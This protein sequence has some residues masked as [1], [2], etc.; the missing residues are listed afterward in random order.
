MGRATIEYRLG[1]KQRA[2]CEEGLPVL[3]AIPVQFGL[4]TTN[5]NEMLQFAID[6]LPDVDP[7]QIDSVFP[8]YVW[9][10]LTNRGG[11][12]EG[13]LTWVMGE[14]VSRSKLDDFAAYSVW[15]VIVSINKGKDDSIPAKWPGGAI[16]I[17]VSN[18]KR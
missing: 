14:V 8:G 17:A 3:L 6:Q 11:G 9:A 15:C 1:V 16:N 10:N 2:R 4:D 18:Y 13:S 5:E 12:K 7:A